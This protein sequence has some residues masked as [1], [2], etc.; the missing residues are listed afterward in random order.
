MKKKNK[1]D[2]SS[3]SL[4]SHIGY[5]VII[6][7]L[8]CLYIGGFIDEKAGTGGIFTII[9][10]ILGAAAGILNIFKITDKYTKRKWPCEQGFII[11]NKQVGCS[12]QFIHHWSYGFIIQR[13]QGTYFGLHIWDIDQYSFTLFDEW[14]SK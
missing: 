1:I 12:A 4:L 9:F 5:S 3:L 14:F 2:Y 8:L 6:P 10:I 13:I 11:Q 7:I